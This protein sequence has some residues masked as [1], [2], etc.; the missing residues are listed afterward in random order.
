M[1]TA[2]GYVY[3]DV[4]IVKT[5]NSPHPR[6]VRGLIL[7]MLRAMAVL[8]YAQCTGAV[9][10]NTN[11]ITHH[12][13]G[14]CGGPPGFGMRTAPGLISKVYL[15]DRRCADEPLM[16]HTRP[17]EILE[18]SQLPHIQRPTGLSSRC[19]STAWLCRALCGVTGDGVLF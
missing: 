2:P 6:Q 12:S 11:W 13:T 17:A 10:S 8:R 7:L 16:L 14:R 5:V 19:P 9:S 4:Q 18:P 1:R 15:H 3:T